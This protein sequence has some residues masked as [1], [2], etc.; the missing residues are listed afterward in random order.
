MQAE[1]QRSLD[2]QVAETRRLRQKLESSHGAF[3]TLDAQH[4]ALVEER[5][6]ILQGVG[7]LKRDLNRV[8]Q[9]AA[10]LGEDIRLA[11]QPALAT[12]GSAVAYGGG[13]ICNK[14]VP[15]A[16]RGACLRCK[17]QVLT[18][19]L[20]CRAGCLDRATRSKEEAKGLLVMI[21]YLKA[22]F[23][24]ESYLRADLAHQKLYLS[25]VIEQ[26]TRM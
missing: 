9:D 19:T 3:S 22:K 17:N 20:P 10:E 23:V 21:K 11:K 8:Q 14:S 4:Q 5:N 26:K 24:R 15:I 18:C 6:S 13:A 2:A 1:T 25:M 12:A 16:Q 7:A